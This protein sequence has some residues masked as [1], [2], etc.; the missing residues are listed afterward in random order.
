MEADPIGRNTEIQL[1]TAA[2]SAWCLVASSRA[3][4]L[5]DVF[6]PAAE[7]YGLH[8]QYERSLSWQIPHP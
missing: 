8:D 5:A 2:R 1:E 4:R 3:P 6:S 7:G